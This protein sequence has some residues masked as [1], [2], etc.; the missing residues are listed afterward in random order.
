MYSI[1][2]THTRG[3]LFNYIYE[4]EKRNCRLT[5]KHTYSEYILSHTAKISIFSD[6]QNQI[7]TGIRTCR[8]TQHNRKPFTKTHLERYPKK[9]MPNLI[10]EVQRYKNTSLA[11]E[12]PTKPGK[13]HLQPQ[14]RYKS[15]WL[16]QLNNNNHNPDTKACNHTS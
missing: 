11:Q 15:T 10:P 4:T 14:P 16:Y 7:K 3:N 13:G 1:V 12:H 9:C 6:E 8:S 2:L 5:Q